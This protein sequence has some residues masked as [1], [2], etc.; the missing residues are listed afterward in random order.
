MVGA[1]RVHRLVILPPGAFVDGVFT[2]ELREDD[3]S[4]IGVDTRRASFA[5]DI[6]RRG[7][8]YLPVL[9][10]F[11]LDL[12]GITVEV[13][14]TELDPALVQRLLHDPRGVPS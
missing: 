2:G 14:A 12:M 4:L 6:V 8:D 9:R 11:Q 7:H 3:G 13:D 5:A 1:V 10:P